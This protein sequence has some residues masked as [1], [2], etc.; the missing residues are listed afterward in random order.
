MYY[1][2]SLQIA[3]EKAWGLV[4]HARQQQEWTQ[5]EWAEYSG[6]IESCMQPIDGI[7]VMS[8]GMSSSS[9]HLP[10]GNGQLALPAP[11]PEVDLK[12]VHE[13]LIKAVVLGEKAL[14][15]VADAALVQPHTQAP[16]SRAKE[17]ADKLEGHMMEAERTKN[18]CSF[19]LKL[20]KSILKGKPLSD[21]DKR[22]LETAVK[23]LSNNIIEEV[24]ILRVVMT[25]HSVPQGKGKG[26]GK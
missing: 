18:E 2:P 21:D 13:K 17:S 12:S 24:K 6:A 19:A 3:N 9:Q 1:F 4:E 25:D 8:A 7:D 14:K 16:A 5:S 10:I 22:T 20:G 15:L 23:A 11:P 26:K